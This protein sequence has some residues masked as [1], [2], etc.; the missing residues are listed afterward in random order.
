MSVGSMAPSGALAMKKV[1]ERRRPFG[2]A[3]AQYAAPGLHLGLA[4]AC[5]GPRLHQALRQSGAAGRALSARAAPPM[6]R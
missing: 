6:V 3:G 4:G 1:G 2:M 5:D